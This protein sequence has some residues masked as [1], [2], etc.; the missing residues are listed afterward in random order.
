MN[1]ND[2][3]LAGAVLSRTDAYVVIG[4]EIENTTGRD[5]VVCN[6]L[7]RDRT[8]D[9]G[10]VV[11]PDVVFIAIESG[12]RP[13]VTKRVPERG[14]DVNVEYP[15]Q[16][17][18]TLLRPGERF[19]EQIRLSLPI[20]PIDA[21]L[22][23]PPPNPAW[24]VPSSGLSLTLGWFARDTLDDLLVSEV[25][26]TAG[27]LPLIKASWVRQSIARL[28]LDVSVPVMPPPPATVPTRQC[29]RCGALNRGEQDACLRCGMPLPPPAPPAGP[30][31]RPT[32]RV[33]PG[34][35]PTFVAPGGAPSAPLDAGLPVQVV[36]QQGDWAQ[37]VAWTGWT[38]WVD[39]RYLAPLG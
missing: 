7:Y 20:G 21:Y 38:G 2:L 11:D 9:G 24:A 13:E 12:P 26:T 19:A 37:V 32:H 6:R 28:D 25:N 15:Y 1:A 16:P 3:R 18:A 30:G 29:A 17:L 4:Y 31:W 35:L 14:D 8:P 23:Q 22:K 10:Y 33:P 36:A 34:G 5:V 27:R 39:G